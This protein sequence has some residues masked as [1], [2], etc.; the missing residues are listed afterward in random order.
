MYIL[1]HLLHLL[2]LPPLMLALLPGLVASRVV[3]MCPR[4]MSHSW[5]WS[6][7]MHR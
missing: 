6:K 7:T 4:D 5:G 2:H 3:G 1:L